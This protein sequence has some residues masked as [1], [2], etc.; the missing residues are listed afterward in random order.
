MEIWQFSCQDL[1]HFHCQGPG[2]IPGV[3]TKISEMAQHGQK[4][5]VGKEEEEEPKEKQ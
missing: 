5:I 3:R 1:Q 4:K 2:S